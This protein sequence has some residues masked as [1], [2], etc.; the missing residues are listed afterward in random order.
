M[1]RLI[2]SGTRTDEAVVYTWDGNKLTK[3]FEI[4]FIK[5]GLGRPHIMQFGQ[6]QFYKNQI[7]AAGAKSMEVA[8]H[9]TK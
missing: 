8:L 4:D 2:E 6:D 3:K 9:P 1:I 7:Y 5:E